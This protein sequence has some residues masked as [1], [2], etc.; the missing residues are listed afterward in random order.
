[1]GD[2]SQHNISSLPIRA[3]YYPNAIEKRTES[4]NLISAPLRRATY[5]LVPASN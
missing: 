1:M 4:T 3:E 2:N 5:R